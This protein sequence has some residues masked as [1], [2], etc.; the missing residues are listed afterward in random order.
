MNNFHNFFQNPRGNFTLDELIYNRKLSKWDDANRNRRPLTPYA[1]K[2]SET[3]EAGLKGS[4][5]S[6][7]SPIIRPLGDIPAS[8]DEY[9]KELLIEKYQ[10][11][12]LWFRSQDLKDW[13]ALEKEDAKVPDILPTVFD[14]L[15]D[16]IA[17]PLRF[18]NWN[19][20]SQPSRVQIPC[21]IQFWDRGEADVWNAMLPAL[22][23]ASRIIENPQTNPL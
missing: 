20:P 16:G 3:E 15:N 5:K 1:Q 8:Q 14:H 21:T 4:G 22:R 6:G 9:N 18:E 7:L 2:Y 12:K 10:A 13:G 17:P 11:G 19:F 23:L